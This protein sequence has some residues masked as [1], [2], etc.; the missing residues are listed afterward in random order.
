ME[1][2]EISFLLTISY[3]FNMLWFSAYVLGVKQKFRAPAAHGRWVVPGSMTSTTSYIHK[4]SRTN[5]LVLVIGWETD[6]PVDRSIFRIRYHNQTIQPKKYRDIAD[7]CRS[8]MKGFICK[9]HIFSYKKYGDIK[10]QIMLI[11]T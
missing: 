7:T 2:A 5:V 9:S 6:T 1:A 8:Q 11:K 4:P 3:I 10:I